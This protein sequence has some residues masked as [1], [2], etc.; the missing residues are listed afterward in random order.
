[1]KEVVH[2]WLA[3]QPKTFFSESI[4]SLCNDGPSALK[5]KGTMLKCDVNVNFL[6][7]VKQD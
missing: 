4:R 5:G 1:V 2:T 6:S 7:V 3:A